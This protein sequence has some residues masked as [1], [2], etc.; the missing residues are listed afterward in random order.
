MPEPNPARSC[1]A[2]PR[3]ACAHLVLRWREEASI[4]D[5]ILARQLVLGHEIGTVTEPGPQTAPPG[6]RLEGDRQAGRR[7]D[8][9]PLEGWHVGEPRYGIGIDL[10]NESGRAVLVD[11]ADGRECATAVNRCADKVY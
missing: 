7:S 8:L 6:T 4:G 5:A 1:S 3:L 2:Q 9:A 11:V 10:G